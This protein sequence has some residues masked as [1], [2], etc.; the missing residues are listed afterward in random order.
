MAEQ[1]LARLFSLP[2]SLPLYL[3]TSFYRG[4]LREANIDISARD[5]CVLS[6]ARE[7]R[8]ITRLKDEAPRCC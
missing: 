7:G 4:A 6:R 5:R 8:L 2:L 3:F 1:G